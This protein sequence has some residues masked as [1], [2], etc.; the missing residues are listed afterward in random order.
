MRPMTRA[1]ILFVLA[2]VLAP[3]PI[4]FLLLASHAASQFLCARIYRGR[5]GIV[6]DLCALSSTLILCGGLLLAAVG[7]FVLMRRRRSRLK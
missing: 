5:N 3:V 6:S 2:V 4:L 7:A 1:A